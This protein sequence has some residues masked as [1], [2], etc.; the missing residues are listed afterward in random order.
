MSWFFRVG[1]VSTSK[2]KTH[3]EASTGTQSRAQKLARIEVLHVAPALSM[4]C[5]CRGVTI[6]MW[7]LQSQQKWAPECK[8]LRRQ[9]SMDFWFF[10]SQRVFIIPS[11]ILF[12]SLRRL[13]FVTSRLSNRAFRLFKMTSNMNEMMVDAANL[14]FPDANYMDYHFMD[15]LMGDTKGQCLKWGFI[16]L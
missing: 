3:V 16:E 5:M 8:C 2:K 6:S 15:S 1:C 14:N 10:E 12:F 4:H 13:L 7:Y 11:Y 9:I